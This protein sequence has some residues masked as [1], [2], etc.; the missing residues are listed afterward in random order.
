QRLLA[1]FAQRTARLL[2]GCRDCPDVL[3]PTSRRL[4]VALWQPN[5]LALQR[6]FPRRP[7]LLTECAGPRDR[8]ARTSGSLRQS[9]LWSR[10]L[11]AVRLFPLAQSKLPTHPRPA[12]P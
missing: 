7:D 11:D 5:G 6:I 1:S 9:A 10:A 4:T 2:D 12:T 8:A 3:R